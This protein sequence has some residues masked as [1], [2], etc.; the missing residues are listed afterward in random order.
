MHHRRRIL[1]RTHLV[2][3]ASSTASVALDKHTRQLHLLAVGAVL[4]SLTANLAFS[5]TQTGG[6]GHGPCGFLDTGVWRAQ[7]VA[8]V[9]FFRRHGLR[10]G[11]V[12]CSRVEK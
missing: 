8:G 2:L 7:L 3:A 5:T 12:V 6:L 9:F 11:H 4:D 10:P 1:A